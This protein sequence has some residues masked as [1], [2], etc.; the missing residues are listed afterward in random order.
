[1]PQW[2]QRTAAEDYDSKE[3]VVVDTGPEPSAFFLEKALEDPRII[4][5]NLLGFSSLSELTNRNTWDLMD[6]MGS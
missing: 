4:Y 2:D 3:L 6:L 1:M 5:R